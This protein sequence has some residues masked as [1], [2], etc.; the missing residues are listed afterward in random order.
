M[1]EGGR[2]QVPAASIVRAG[3]S[4][5]VTER[6]YM[7]RLATRRHALV[8]AL[9]SVALLGACTGNTD[10]G[11]QSAPTPAVAATAAATTA[12]RVL[13]AAVAAL[14]DTTPTGEAARQASFTGPALESANAWAKTLPGKTDAQKADAQL[15][16]TGAK[17]IGV[18]RVGDTPRQ[19]VVQT[20]L[21][22]SDAA[23]LVLLV[24]DQASA[25][26][27]VAAITPM[28][29]EARLDA[30]DST[31]TGSAAIGGGAGLAMTPDAAMQAFA[32][33]VRFPKPTEASAL[34]DDPL[35]NELRQ[36]AAAQ[37][38]AIE[39]SGAFTQTHQP[40]GTLG[41]LRL[42]DG[43]GAVVFT[44]FVRTDDIAMR[45]PV[46][47]KPSQ[48]FTLLTG[49]K[50]ITSE[51]SLVSNEIVVFVIPASGSAR[52]IAASDQLVSGTA[53]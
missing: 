11:A 14:S 21:E 4:R 41:G 47:L 2:T 45:T 9:A 15:A 13:T 34:L 35:T 16:T 36:S 10:E 19:L 33:S 51:A 18:S 3:R 50:Q 23:V 7:L 31:S 6:L 29:P 42:K 37:D 28:L 22:K 44:H 17:V 53:R 12:D 30:L 39:T 20:T 43:S 38:K 8:A 25:D 5:S 48:D 24:S 40:K 26:F 49:I 52:V 1:V 32:D 27:K 46:Q